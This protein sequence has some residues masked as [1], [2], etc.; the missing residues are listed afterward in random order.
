MV[1]RSP[2]HAADRSDRLR[3]VIALIHQRWGARSVSLGADALLRA[4]TAAPPLS[5]TSL[6]LDLL[7]GGLPGGAIT[8]IAGRDGT[9]TESLGAAVLASCQRGG[10]LVVLVD[11]GLFADPDALAASGIDLRSLIL[12]SPTTAQEAWTVIDLFAR[13]G[14]PHLLVASLLGLMAAPGA[15]ASVRDRGL[16]RLATSV[17]GRQTAVVFLSLPLGSSAPPGAP[18]G[19]LS[20]VGGAVLAQVAALRVLL[21]PTGVRLS[22]YGDLAAL[23]TTLS[24]AK[25]HG[26]P[27]GI[28]L[29]LEM[30]EY[31]VHRELELITL[32]CLLGLVAESNAGLSYNGALMGKSRLAAAALLGHTPELAAA[33]EQQIRAAWS[34]PHVAHRLAAAAG[35]A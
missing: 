17:R 34:R 6:G 22:A 35:V 31:G 3:R 20:T 12:A 25:Y 27:Q 2:R 16:R 4:R 15:S 8:E 24:V 10:G 19:S 5:T 14:C 32:G 33:L 29:P 23:T 9:G 21:A 1:T 30:R 7:T 28:A 26:M 18:L 13:S 11:A